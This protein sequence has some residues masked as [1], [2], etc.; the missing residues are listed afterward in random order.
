MDGSKYFGK[1]RVINRSDATIYCWVQDE[2]GPT[3][4]MLGPGRASPANR[5]VD[6]FRGYCRGVP[7]KGAADQVKID[8]S[9]D[10]VKLKNGTVATVTGSGGDLKFSTEMSSAPKKAV[11]A[12]AI[13]GAVL[14]GCFGPIGMAVGAVEAGSLARGKFLNNYRM[15]EEQIDKAGGIGGHQPRVYSGDLT[16]GEP[17]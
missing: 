8:D 5:D 12:S 2:D 11:G 6:C 16:W 15:T 10:W 14:M 17:I 1:G 4:F 3:I 7:R 9:L 13:G